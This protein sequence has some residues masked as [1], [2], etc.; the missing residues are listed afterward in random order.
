MQRQGRVCLIHSAQVTLSSV[1]TLNRGIEIQKWVQEQSMRLGQKSISLGKRGTKRW[2]HISEGL[3]QAEALD[4]FPTGRFPN[5]PNQKSGHI[6][7]Q[8]V[9]LP[10]PNVRGKLG[11]VAWMLKVK[12]SRTL[13]CFIKAVNIW[14]QILCSRKSGAYSCRT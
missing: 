4:W 7:W 14:N 5:F 12:I 13:W 9:F 2:L 1:T 3:H 6:T 8:R 10:L 11:H